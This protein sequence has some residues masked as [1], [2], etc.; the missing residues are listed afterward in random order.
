LFA[1]GNRVAPKEIRDRIPQEGVTELITHHKVAAAPSQPWR[2]GPIK[3][4]NAAAIATAYL[5]LAAGLC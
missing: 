4:V 3:A 2:R 1:G 5:E